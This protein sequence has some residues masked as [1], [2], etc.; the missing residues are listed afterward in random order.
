MVNRSIPLPPRRPIAQP[1]RIRPGLTLLL[2]LCAGG[3]AA[4]FDPPSAAVLFSC[5]PDN[6]P[7]CPPGYTCEIDGCCHRD[8][9]DFEEHRNECRVG[10]P[11]IPTSSGTGMDSGTGGTGATGSTSAAPDTDSSGTAGGGTTGGES[12]TDA[13]TDSGSGSGATGTSGG[14]Q[15]GTTGGSAGGSTGP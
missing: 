6:A 9:G 13:Q 10:D 4:C 11:E 14:P 7:A 15:T 3:L 8:G 12:S 2:G 1:S 5:D